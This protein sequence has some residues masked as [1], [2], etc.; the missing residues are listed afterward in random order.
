ME[1]QPFSHLVTPNQKPIAGQVP[2]MRQSKKIKPGH[3]PISIVNIKDYFKII[4]S[5]S[6]SW[7]G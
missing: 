1:A 5:C 2:N 3:Y 6:K 4:N 7:D